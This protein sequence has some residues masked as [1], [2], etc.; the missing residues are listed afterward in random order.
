MLAYY[1]IG[2]I[3]NVK[4]RSRLQHYISVGRYR[5]RLQIQPAISDTEDVTVRPVEHYDH[6]LNEM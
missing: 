1:I 6:L 2:I 5:I 3:V 4:G